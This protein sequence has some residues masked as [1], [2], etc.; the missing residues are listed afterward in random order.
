MSPSY[1]LQSAPPVNPDPAYIAASAAAQIITSDY[2]S[3]FS[4]GT[5]NQPPYVAVVAPAS[6]TLVNAFL[7]RLLY[8]FLAS[9]RSTSLGSLRPAVQEVLK[10]RLAKEAIAGADEE[11]EEFLGGGDEEELLAFHGGQEP[12]GEWDLDLV[13]RRTR[14][15]CMVYTRLG[16]MEEEEEDMY[17]SQEHL[18]EVSDER[19]L[20]RELGSVSPAVAIF[21]TS[22]LEFVGELAL[23]IAG[24]AAYNK[25]EKV[26]NRGQ[27]QRTEEILV[28]EIDMEKVAFNPTL[29]RLWRS[30]RRL[31]RSPANSMSRR[32][33]LDR[34]NLS[35]MRNFS[36]NGP[37]QESKYSGEDDP[38]FSIP[39]PV[40][41][42]SR[43]DTDPVTIPLPSTENDV[44]EIE[45]PGYAPLAERRLHISQASF[46]RPHSMLG[47]TTF[48]DPMYSPLQSRPQSSDM[49]AISPDGE[50]TMARTRSHSLPPDTQIPSLAGENSVEEQ[51]TGPIIVQ[52]ADSTPSLRPRDMP[53]EQTI[54]SKT[55]KGLKKDSPTSSGPS[56]GGSASSMPTTPLQGSVLNAISRHAARE[57]SVSSSGASEALGSRR[58]A[59][60]EAEPQEGGHPEVL[61]EIPQPDQHFGLGARGIVRKGAP[62]M[63]DAGKIEEGGVSPIIRAVSPLVGSVSPIAND[64][65]PSMS[66]SSF[67]PEDVSPIDDDDDE[68]PF[69]DSDSNE[70][71]NEDEDDFNLTT[72]E[73]YAIQ[74]APQPEYIPMNQPSQTLARDE[75]VV[76][77]KPLNIR[78]RRVLTSDELA[79][80][81]NREAYIVLDDSSSQSGWNSG[82][83]TLSGRDLQLDGTIANRRVR[84]GGAGDGIPPLTPLRET[85]ETAHDTSD[86]ISSGLVSQKNRL[87]GSFNERA[88]SLPSTY[89]HSRNPSAPSIISRS[90]D[91]R[92]QLPHL[93]TDSYSDRAGVQRLSPAESI[94]RE[95]AS[96]QGRRSESSAR[97]MT[98]PI[99][100]SS[101][102]SQ[103]LKGLVGWQQNGEDSAGTPRASGDRNRGGTAGNPRP[104]D[105]GDEK[106]RS[107]DQLIQSD[108]TIQYTLTPNVM[109]QIEVCPLIQLGVNN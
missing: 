96:P 34:P 45:V 107:F 63:L 94:P 59:L 76:E 40:V 100:G 16:D 69:I 98:A 92:Y 75:P 80:G 38:S 21:L 68:R 108:Q 15:R 74:S 77:P 20:S 57:L 105:T 53:V 88:E 70:L 32:M 54:T 87:Q 50:T 73:D 39:D 11:I 28:E 1:S 22:I 66:A 23:T 71:L 91:S 65:P 90:S 31:M 61:S 25:N 24:D 86:A 30:W 84:T 62:S 6:L 14:L 104:T 82:T 19:R 56:S 3:H 81:D 35:G 103:K 8:N 89:S 33:S 2:R 64:F 55:L 60:D 79:K 36:H 41:P 99:S 109:R 72:N 52:P 95:P 10:P 78:P 7:D 67:R 93:N 4:E 48:V 44:A 106:Q 85:I 58:G 13:W 29:G 51:P 97:F 18:D 17:I 42:S 27:R 49:R 12:T 46:N 26:R 83:S 102:V 47:L 5:D 43:E 9:A 37:I 101:P